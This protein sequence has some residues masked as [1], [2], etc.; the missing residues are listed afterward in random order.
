M[1]R[2]GET[3]SS[4]HDDAQ[5]EKIGSTFLQRLDIPRGGPFP[6]AF[7]P[8]GA[9]GS[10]GFSA[11]ALEVLGGVFDFHYMGRAEYEHGECPRALSTIWA[12]SGEGKLRHSS[13][14]ASA[15][16]WRVYYICRRNQEPAVTHAILMLAKGERNTRDPTN[17]DEIVTSDYVGLHDALLRHPRHPGETA[18]W[19]DI[20][21]AYMFFVSK[22][23]YT[24]SLKLFETG[25]R[26]T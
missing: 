24:K 17:V 9:G 10:G 1:T 21:H 13:L 6:K 18:G 26:D 2:K 4:S 23:M 11:M 8:F 19:L 14:K 22:S 5:N 7:T 20:I 25:R 12:Y 16:G 3:H 15:Y